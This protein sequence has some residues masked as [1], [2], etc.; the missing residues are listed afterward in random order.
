[1][2]H[3]LQMIVLLYLF[4]HFITNNRGIRSRWPVIIFVAG[5][6][7]IF[8]FMSDELSNY[9]S[10][11]LYFKAKSSFRRIFKYEIAFLQYFLACERAQKLGLFGDQ[12]PFPLSFLCGADWN[13]VRQST[14]E[15]KG[16]NKLDSLPNL[17]RAAVGLPSNQSEWGGGVGR[18]HRGPG[19][20]KEEQQKSYWESRW[21]QFEFWL[22][23]IRHSF[24]YPD[25]GVIF[26]LSLVI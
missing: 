11:R 7:W 13:L 2:E 23:V 19:K 1:M 6:Y 25:S 3:S 18:A 5:I 10:F 16:R 22:V 4:V 12:T 14:R 21:E 26:H 15:L 17:K 8:I 24:V 20:S 9:C